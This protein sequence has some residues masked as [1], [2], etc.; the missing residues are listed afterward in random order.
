[1]NNTLPNP[2]REKK[3]VSQYAISKTHPDSTGRN[4][5][6]K[7]QF[8]SSVSVKTSEHAK[9]VFKKPKSKQSRKNVNKSGTDVGKTG[10]KRK[11]KGETNERTKKQ[12]L[13]ENAGKYNNTALPKSG[14]K[15]SNVKESNKEAKRQN[16]MEI[17]NS[18]VAATS[19]DTVNIHVE[20]NKANSVVEA[21]RSETSAKQGKVVSQNQ[22]SVTKKLPVKQK[23]KKI[24]QKN[25]SQERSSSLPE[26]QV[27]FTNT[28]ED[29]PR[30]GTVKPA[31]PDSH[32]NEV[33]VTFTNNL[34]STSAAPVSHSERGICRSKKVVFSDSLD[35]VKGR[36]DKHQ[37][38]HSERWFNKKSEGKK[39]NRKNK[40]NKNST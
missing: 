15:R 14:K 29:F 33:H 6:D 34:C 22:K 27:T 25:S 37:A 5:F 3:L 10:D 30:G 19:K 28:E 21:T 12:K 23:K 20:I 16:S 35:N 11:H 18:S 1:M 40:A 26:I 7:L 13:M 38:F 8:S 4:N 2:K 31:I 9:D 39:R 24:K 32:C 17:A 36:G